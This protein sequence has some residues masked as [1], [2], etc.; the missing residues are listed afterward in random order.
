MCVHF[1][2]GSVRCGAEMSHSK[3]PQHG[4]RHTSR[5]DR[6]FNCKIIDYMFNNGTVKKINT[7]NTVVDRGSRS[8]EDRGQ[9]ATRVNASPRPYSLI[10]TF[11]LDFQSQ[12]NYGHDPHAYTNSSSKISGFKRQSGNKRTDGRTLP[13]ALPSRITR[14]V[15]M[16]KIKAKN[17]LSPSRTPL[18]YQ[19]YFPHPCQF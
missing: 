16:Y 10:L 8:I 1:A 11:D 5:L 4:L 18:S 12:A 2:V 6:H 19:S 17:R 9:T 7:R 13:I 14:S 15:K 3:H